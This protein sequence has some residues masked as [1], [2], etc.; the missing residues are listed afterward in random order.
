MNRVES[1]KCGFLIAGICIAV[2]GVVSAAQ[3]KDRK[4]AAV[5][6]HQ[7]SVAPTPTKPYPPRPKA[8]APSI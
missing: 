3:A 1:V 6:P 7:V 8:R 4:S 5:E 2:S